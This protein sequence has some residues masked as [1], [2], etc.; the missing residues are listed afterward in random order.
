[1]EPLKEHCARAHNENLTRQDL[2]ANTT[3]YRQFKHFHEL[4]IHEAIQIMKQSPVLNRQFTGTARTLLLLGD[5]TT[6]CQPH[7][8]QQAAKSL[9]KDTSRQAN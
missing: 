3:I 1:M 4:Q 5:R 8:D 9:P 2:V 7:A 6:V